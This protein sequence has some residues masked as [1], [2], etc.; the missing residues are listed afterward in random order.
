MANTNIPDVQLNDGNK[1]PQLGFGVFK[2]PDDET[3]R[4][5]EHAIAAGYRSIDTAAFYQNER[6]VGAG[7]ANSGVPRDE[8][9]ITSKVWNDAHGRDNARRSFLESLE[10]LKLD[11]LDMFLIHWPVPSR[12]LYVETWQALV[13]LQAE[14]LVTSIGVSNFEP[15][16]L[17]RLRAESGVVPVVNQVELHPYLVQAAVREYDAA[18]GIVTEAWSPLAKGGDL[19]E[20]VVLTE[21]GARYGKSPAQVVIRWHIQLGNVVIPKSVTPARMSQNIDVF[22][23]ALTQAELDAVSALDS[24]KRTGPN[25]NVFVAPPAA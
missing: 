6:G 13:E 24:D 18:H 14:G 7:I 8:L 25:P 5:V 2:V 1:I 12:D 9:F 17:E 23:F 4:A 11:R 16:H 3:Q 10:K 21:I 20:Q 22:D 15:A 19:L